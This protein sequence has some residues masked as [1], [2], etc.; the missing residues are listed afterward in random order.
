MAGLIAQGEAY[1]RLTDQGLEQVARADQERQMTNEQIKGAK[2]QQGVSNVL[3]GA[4]LGAAIGQGAA[5]GGPWGAAIGAG[6]GLL[7]S[8]L[9]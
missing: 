1:K 8:L 7:G 3:G 9:G 6:I 2:R 4:G 5:V